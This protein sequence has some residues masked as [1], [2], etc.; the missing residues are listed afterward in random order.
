MCRKYWMV[1]ANIILYN[2]WDKDNGGIFN[3]RSCGGGNPSYI[4]FKSLPWPLRK[5]IDYKN[6]Q[7]EPWSM[8]IGCICIYRMIRAWMPIYFCQ[9]TH[10]RCIR[11][12]GRRKPYVASRDVR[13]GAQVVPYHIRNTLAFYWKLQPHT[14]MFY[15]L[16][17]VIPSIHFAQG[18]VA[19]YAARWESYMYSCFTWFSSIY[20]M[21]FA[22]FHINMGKRLMCCAV[23]GLLCERRR[24]LYYGKVVFLKWN[25]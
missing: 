19:R 14:S 13:S 17:N 3:L 22:L 18:T 15:I 4:N 2:K 25:C 6:R 11:P 23:D 8:A 24:S 16:Y 1:S 21:L 12:I 9:S 7:R 20:T 10:T 5:A